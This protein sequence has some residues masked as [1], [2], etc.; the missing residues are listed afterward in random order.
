MSNVNVA[1][2]FRQMS[3]VAVN[4]GLDDFCRQSNNFYYI[5]IALLMQ[6][7]VRR[8][9]PIC[10]FEYTLKRMRVLI[11]FSILSYTQYILEP[12]TVEAKSLAMFE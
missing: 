11:F 9:F 2:T 7:T 6:C 12:R 4:Y 1:M 10:L 8:L 5:F 3:F